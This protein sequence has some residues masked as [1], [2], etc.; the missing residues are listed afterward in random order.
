MEKYPPGFD[1]MPRKECRKFVEKL[2]EEHMTNTL[3]LPRVK[4]S[5]GCENHAD[6]VHSYGDAILYET[7]NIK[8]RVRLILC[9]LKD[10]E[11]C[12]GA[13]FTRAQPITDVNAVVRS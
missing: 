3:I 10:N 9:P 4:T 1:V 11:S 6:R 7:E 2:K 12:W 5:Q 8:E 13:R